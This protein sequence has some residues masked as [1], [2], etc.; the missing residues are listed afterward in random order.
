M[1]ITPRQPCVYFVQLTSGA[2]KVGRTVDLK[3]RLRQL[4][5][6]FGPVHL[7][8]T[9]YTDR[10]G[11]LETHLLKRWRNKAVIGREV[12]ALTE[13]DIRFARQVS[14]VTYADR[15]LASHRPHCTCP[16]C[17]SYRAKKSA[18]PRTAAPARPP[19]PKRRGGV[20]Y[21]A[22]RDQ[23]YTFFR[24]RQVP[25]NVYGKDAREEAA[26]VLS[27]MLSRVGLAP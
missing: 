23:W 13:D 15:P 26:R 19:K 14:R 25:L 12:L 16:H 4:G 7:L 11:D 1:T 24:G 5:L 20:W 21:R 18:T 6:V 27:E 17:A 22:A 3:R 10:P 9:I 8:H 2:V